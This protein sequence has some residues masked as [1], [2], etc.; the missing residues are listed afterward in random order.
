MFIF[1]T[2]IKKILNKGIFFF[3]YTK[4]KIVRTVVMLV[5]IV[6]LVILIMILVMLLM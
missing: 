5:M 3:T 2:S 6:M 1:D 4:V